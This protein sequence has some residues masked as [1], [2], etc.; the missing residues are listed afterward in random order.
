MLQM[1]SFLQG[2][3]DMSYNTDFIVDIFATLKSFSFSDKDQ[4]R[5]LNDNSLKNLSVFF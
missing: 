4:T 1:W 5:T 2:F 3:W